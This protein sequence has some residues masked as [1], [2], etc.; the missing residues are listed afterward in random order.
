[1]RNKYAPLSKFQ[2]SK[3]IPPTNYG[4]ITEI[5]GSHTFL[6]FSALIGI[7]NRDGGSSK[8]SEGQSELDGH[9]MEQV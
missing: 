1:M 3:Q 4:M 8:K 6:V 2:D 5:I 9:L 7:D